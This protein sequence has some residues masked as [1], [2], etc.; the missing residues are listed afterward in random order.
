[1]DTHR[2]DLPHD[3]IDQRRRQIASR[4]RDSGHGAFGGVTVDVA[5]TELWIRGT[6]G[7]YYAKQMASELCRSVVPELTIR[8]ALVV[9]YPE[10]RDR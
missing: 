8:N 10:E 6:V 7:S 9:T 2:P 3:G 1:M 5:G 4:L